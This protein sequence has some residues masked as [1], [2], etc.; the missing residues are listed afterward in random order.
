MARLERASEEVWEIRIYDTRPQIRFFGRFADRNVFVALIGPIGR[1]NATFNWDRI[2]RQCIG[3]W[4][5]L[6]TYLPVAK[7]DDIDAYL[8]N[9]NLV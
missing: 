8:S 6:F 3:E 2:K 1:A 4:R 5:K 9:V 7:G